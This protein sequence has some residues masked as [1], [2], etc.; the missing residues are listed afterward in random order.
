MDGDELLKKELQSLKS[1]M[2][3]KAE[4]KV[5]FFNDI[6]GDWDS[7]KSAILGDLDVSLHVIPVLGPDDVAADLG[8][9]TGLLMK[10]M[11]GKAARIIGVDKSPA[12]LE[13]ARSRLSGFC[14]G[15]P[16]LRIGELEHLPM[17]DRELDFAVINMVLQYLRYPVRPSVK[18]PGPSAREELS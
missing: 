18:R 17:R 6:A 9:G 15:E 14:E 4:E 7:I 3:K 1:M 5:R 13:M 10:E 2:E 16:D 11:R 12:M 8:C